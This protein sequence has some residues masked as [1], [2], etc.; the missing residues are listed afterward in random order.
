[1][2]MKHIFGIVITVLIALAGCGKNKGA[3]SSYNEPH[4]NEVEEY[5]IEWK[6]LFNQDNDSY[7]AYVYSVTC[8]PCSMLR[9]EIINF[10]KGHY[11]NFYFIYPSDDISFTEDSSIADASLGKSSINDV[12]I[13]TTPTLIGITNKTITSYSRDYYEIKA[14][15][16]SFN[17]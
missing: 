12:Y 6:E 3:T 16:E 5:H 13:Y 15:I 1:M 11:V 17:N 8:T 7:Y 10:A 2:Y 14:F 9:E 4:Y